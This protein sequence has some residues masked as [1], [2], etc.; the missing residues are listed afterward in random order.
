[1]PGYISEIDYFGGA[2]TEWVEIAV[3]T[4]T[5][6][7]GY[8]LLVYNSAGNLSATLSLGTVQSTVAGEDVYLVNS[9]TPG[10]PGLA[11]GEGVALVD[12]TDSVLQF[13]SYKGFTVTANDGAAAGMT[14]VNA[15]SGAEHEG[16]SLQTSDGGATYYVQNPSNPGTIPC[17]QPDTLIETPE[18]PRRAATLRPGDLVHTLDRGP[19]P[20]L[21]ARIS[22][23][24]PPHAGEIGRLTERSPWAAVRIRAGAL[25][26]GRPA[27]DLV[28]SGQHRIL[29][30][31]L[32]QLTTHFSTPC[33]VPAKALTGLPGI[34][35]LPCPPGGRRW[36][37]F[38]FARHAIV[39]AAGCYSESLL[40]GETMLAGLSLRIGAGLRDDFAPGP[41]TVKAPGGPPA[42]ACP[43]PSEPD[44]RPRGVPTPPLNGPPAR[45]CLSVSETRRAIGTPQR[46]RQIQPPPSTRVLSG[47]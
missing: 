27:R 45:P 29:A 22:G 9:G 5:D 13:I 10:W 41:E 7:S 43:G 31:E 19:Q 16:Y 18:G 47:A 28:V 26:P 32:G 42:A 21:W 17:F 37:H 24:I 38:A 30:G 40:L 36:V 39:R 46:P 34:A 4:G 6:V 35:L 12:D 33:L 8:N 2:S 15:G 1:M 44:R 23:P 3:P 14:S 25:G 11:Q 20:I